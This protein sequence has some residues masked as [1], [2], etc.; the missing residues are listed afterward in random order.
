MMMQSYLALGFK[1]IRLVSVVLAMMAAD[2]LAHADVIT[3]YHND[4]LGSPRVATNSSGQVIWTE[5]YSPHGERLNGQLVSNKIWYTSRHQDDDTGLVY[6]GARYY[7]PVTG[8]F[9]GVDPRLFNPINVHTF[10]RYSYANNNPYRYLDPDGQQAVP[11]VI[12]L[13]VIGVG[14]A[15]YLNDPDRRQRTADSVL[16][17]RRRI[18]NIFSEGNEGGSQPKAEKPEVMP[19]PEGVPD[20]WVERPTRDGEGRQ[21]VNPDN[22]G[23]RVRAMPGN[24]QSPNPAQ[25]EPYVRDVRNGNQWLDVKGDRI[26]GK[27]GKNSPTTHIPAKD[28]KFPG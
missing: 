28:Y 5:S 14:G 1:C 20:N 15:I 8:R 4:L 27:E 16:E 3:Y 7:D 9:M 19:R 26:E 18:Q 24:P 21:W 10:N 6:M 11:G 17:L 13:T 22:E 23:D 2:G 25:R 12:A